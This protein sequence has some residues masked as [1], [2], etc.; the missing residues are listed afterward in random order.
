MGS[1]TKINWCDATFNPWI[2]CAKVSEGCSR[3]YA[4]ADMALRRKRVVWGPNGT[5]SKT[6]EDNW[7]EPRRWNDHAHRDHDT[8]TRVVAG[9]ECA[10]DL[11]KAT[12]VSFKR[13]LDSLKR[14]EDRGL[15]AF[16]R[17]YSPVAP[18]SQ[19][20]VFCASLAD[21]FEDWRGPILSH[22]GKPI[23]HGK[24]WGTKEKYVERDE[25]I[26][27][28]LITMD[29]LRRDLFELIDA[30]PYLDWLLLTKRP[31]NIRRM[32][33]IEDAG[34]S[35]PPIPT[36][37]P[38]PVYKRKRRENV[39][40]GTSISLQEHADKQ[41]PEL[42]KCR[43]LSPV[44]FL[45][46]EPLLG[47]INLSA[48]QWAAGPVGQE[49]TNMILVDALRGIQGAGYIARNEPTINW[50]IV[51]GESGAH[52]RRCDVQWIRDLRD[53]CTAAGVP[54]LIKQLG[55]HVTWDGVQGGYMNG[56]PN[57]WPEGM[58]CEDTGQGNFRVY[59]KDDKGGDMA[60]WPEDMRVRQ[61]PEVVRA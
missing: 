4:E 2:G 39:W 37:P 47:P 22:R 57:V 45:S 55:A 13:A 18:Y 32:W 7:R 27:K 28:S 35:A 19:P 51:G 30:T 33:P 31:E 11:A 50:C 25:R 17:V 10:D 29:D 16:D 48:I 38:L 21:V 26:G 8:Y 52:A 6:S 12:G 36:L 9:C 41:V 3:C 60:E 46:A 1:T 40:L 53:Q 23:H 61:F 24:P 59:L 43:D 44:L 20:R 56:T 5:R 15:I 42:L 49:K 54:V 58:R 34:Y 14:L